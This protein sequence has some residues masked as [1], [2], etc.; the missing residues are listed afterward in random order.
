MPLSFWQA[1]NSPFWQH[2]TGS[3]N[4]TWLPSQWGSRL[5]SFNLI[6]SEQQ[7]R[8]RLREKPWVS[9]QNVSEIYHSC[10][11]NWNSN[12]FS[13]QRQIKSKVTFQHFYAWILRLESPQWNDVITVN[14]SRVF[15]K[16]NPA[17]FFVLPSAYSG[18]LSPF[19]TLKQICCYPFWP[20]WQIVAK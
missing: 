1:T 3:V 15:V 5:G 11:K 7:W 10:N 2:C 9:G 17:D 4:P 8:P 12:S 14:T 18:S 6:P 20:K 16:T 13:I 19:L